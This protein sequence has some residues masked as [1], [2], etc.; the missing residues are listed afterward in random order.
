MKMK[1][2]AT[3]I[4]SI[5]I[6]TATIAS[7]CGPR[8]QLTETLSDDYGEHYAFGGIP[9]R[10]NTLM[11]IWVNPISRSY[12]VLITQPNDI[13]CIVAAGTDFFIAI[14]EISKKGEDG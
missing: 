6:G 3:T 1:L 11:E 12:T 9:K 13:S 14:P 4:V 7:T 10:Q 5:F 8:D 2:F